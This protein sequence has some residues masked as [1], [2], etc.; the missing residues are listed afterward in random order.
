M[1]GDFL[2]IADITLLANVTLLEIAVEFELS[3]YPNIWGW[4]N[5]LRRELPY[6][7]QLTKVAHDE[8][9]Q[10]VRSIRDQHEEWSASHYCA[11]MP[12]DKHNGQVPNG[13]SYSA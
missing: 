13:H 9:R 5:R 3:S 12:C 2:T 10:L 6:Y 4:F 1:A 11:F 7:D 8:L